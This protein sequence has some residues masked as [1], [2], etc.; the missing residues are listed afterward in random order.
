MWLILLMQMSSH[1]MLKQLDKYSFN[2]QNIQNLLSS[3]YFEEDKKNDKQKSIKSKNKRKE[4]DFYI[5]SEKDSL[6]WCWFIFKSGF[7]D[8]E[9]NKEFFFSVEK[10][11]KIEFVNKI[12]NNKKMLKHM[13][14][15][16][17]EMEGHLANDSIL[18]ITYLEPM[19][20]IEKYNFIYMN[21]KIYYENITYPGNPTCIVKYFNDVD[22]YG[23]FL[24][25]KKLFDYKD[26]LF[27]VDNIKKPVKGISNYK[28]NELRDIC[29]KLNIDIMKT[30]TKTKTKKEL[31]QLVIEKIL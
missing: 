9:I 27:I 16:V 29:K 18:D 13:K 2:K 8:Y 12:R 6:F 4:V 15:R 7:S 14:I 31:Y 26:K 22:K 1:N 28:A 23:L 21:E 24:D 17:S 10:E 11:N 25:E 30:P 19:L 3:E 5:P 20:I